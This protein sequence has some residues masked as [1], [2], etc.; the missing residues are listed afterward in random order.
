M[1]HN[2]PY[3]QYQIQQIQAFHRY[4]PEWAEW[5]VLQYMPPWLSVVKVAK[6]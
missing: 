5:I 3:A 6:Y 1:K 4:C 2:H